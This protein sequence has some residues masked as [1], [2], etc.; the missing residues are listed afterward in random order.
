MME[1]TK[2]DVHAPGDDL[3][4]PN[5]TESVDVLL[6]DGSRLKTTRSKLLML[7]YFRSHAS[8]TEAAGNGVEDD[9]VI[10]VDLKNEDVGTVKDMFCLLGHVDD[11]SSAM[12]LVEKGGFSPTSALWRMVAW[13]SGRG[14]MLEKNESP[15][16]RRHEFKTLKRGWLVVPCGQGAVALDRY[17]MPN[18]GHGGLP[19][20]TVDGRLLYIVDALLGGEALIQANTASDRATGLMHVP[21]VLNF[22]NRKQVKCHGKPAQVRKARTADRT[23]VPASG[24]PPFPYSDSDCSSWDS[25]CRSPSSPSSSD[26]DS[27]S[28]HCSSFYKKEDYHPDLSKVWRALVP[29]QALVSKRDDHPI[30]HKRKH[31]KIALWEKI[32]VDREGRARFPSKSKRHDRTVFVTRRVHGHPVVINSVRFK[33]ET[34]SDLRGITADAFEHAHPFVYCFSLPK[35]EPSFFRFEPSWGEYDVYVRSFA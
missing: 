26:S 27:D 13:Y 28:N 3:P 30:L 34:V 5:E 25:D 22:E 6:A 10:E 23:R 35:G 11:T 2:G 16:T 20:S 32:P 31:L 29:L 1:A 9:A 7:P 24:R 33:H 21:V 18:L 19:M 14:A 17:S 4:T 12:E 8:F 15:F